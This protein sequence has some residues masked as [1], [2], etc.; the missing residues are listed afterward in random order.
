MPNDYWQLSDAN[1]DY[2]VSVVMEA[3]SALHLFLMR[4]IENSLLL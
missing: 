4:P 3:H 1:R 2:K